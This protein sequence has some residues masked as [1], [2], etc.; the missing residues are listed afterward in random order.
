M[1]KLQESLIAS[2]KTNA[3]NISLTLKTNDITLKEF[4]S[5]MEDPEFADKYKEAEQLWQIM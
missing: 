3:C 4:E 1:N 5:F 2:L